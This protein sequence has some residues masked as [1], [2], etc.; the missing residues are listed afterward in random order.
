M[1]IGA[2]LAVALQVERE[3]QE[4]LLRQ[5][6]G[7][8]D[9][10]ATVRPML[11]P[12]DCVFP[13]GWDDAQRQLPVSQDSMRHRF[14]R[15]VVRAGLPAVVSPHWLRHGMLSAMIAGTDTQPGISIVDAARIAGHANPTITAK[16]YAHAAEANMARGIALA[17][18]WLTPAAPATVEPLRNAAKVSSD[19]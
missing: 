4:A 19:R 10:V 7:L 16:V 13:A 1:P 17:D 8:S 2:S 11:R 5:L 6:H 3:R 12:D 14:K 15:A 18:A 9:N